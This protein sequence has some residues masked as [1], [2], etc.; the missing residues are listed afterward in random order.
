MTEQRNQITDVVALGALV[1]AVRI[2]QGFKR[3]ELAT[4]T[5]LSPKFITQIELG[6]ETAQ[7]GKVLQLLSELGMHLYLETP[8]TTFTKESLES[9]LKRRRSRRNT[10]PEAT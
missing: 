2:A 3:D 8:G 6:K 5:G 1:R 9:A 10:P 7:V 4:A